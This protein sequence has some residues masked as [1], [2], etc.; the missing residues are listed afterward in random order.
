MSSESWSTWAKWNSSMKQTLADAQ[1]A[2]A[3]GEAVTALR[4][5]AGDGGTASVLDV[6]ELAQ[7]AAPGACWVLSATDHHRHFGSK[8]PSKKAI[9]AGIQSFLG[10]LGRGQAVAVTAY[11]RGL[12]TAVLFAGWSNG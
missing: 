7:R 11:S 12:P 1:K 2:A 3:G 9:E 8:T 5:R 6:F 4:R 10:D